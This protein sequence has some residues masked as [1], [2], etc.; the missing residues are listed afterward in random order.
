[1]NWTDKDSGGLQKETCVR[2][3]TLRGLRQAVAAVYDSEVRGGRVELSSPLQLLCVLL[4]CC[5]IGND[6]VHFPCVS[7]K[8]TWANIGNSDYFKNAF[9][10]GYD[11]SL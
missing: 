3:A 7:R 2:K 1:M 8:Q 9:A 10:M 6:R 5:F 11:W 4:T